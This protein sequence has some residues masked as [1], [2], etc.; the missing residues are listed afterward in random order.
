MNL[1]AMRPELERFRAA[2]VEQVG[3][4]FEDAKLGFLDEVLQRRTTRHA[5]SRANYIARLESRPPTGRARRPCAGINRRRNLFFSSQRSIYR[6]CRD[7]PARAHARARSHTNR[8][9]SVGWMRVGRRGVLARDRGATGGHR[10]VV[11]RDYPRHRPQSGR[12]AKG[13]AGPLFGLGA[14]RRTA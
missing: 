13:G 8:A 4:Q 1:A 6:A 12:S 10:C 9:A 7:R 5:C 11:E 3:L 14:A 2:I